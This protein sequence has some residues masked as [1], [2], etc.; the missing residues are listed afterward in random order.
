[1]GERSSFETLRAALADGS[2]VAGVIGL[3][4]VGLP[5]AVSAAKGGFSTIGFDIDPAKAAQLNSGSSY[6]DAVSDD[7]LGPL[8]RDGRF[9][10]TDDFDR[11]AECDVIVICVP[12]PLTRHRE[13]DMSY[14][15]A[16][17][18]ETASRLRPGQLVVLESTT[19]PGT[20]REV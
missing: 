17:A 13:P 7:D 3:G 8:A 20:T 2:A 14:I 11:L 10:A 1:M 12:T 6:I 15:E 4:Y 19:Y 18:R 16:T 5:L 9:V